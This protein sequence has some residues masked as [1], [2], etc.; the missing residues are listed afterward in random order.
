MSESKTEKV[1]IVPGW[2]VACAIGVYVT[3]LIS[4][5]SNLQPILKF[6]AAILP[7]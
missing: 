7:F 6:T 3:G 5:L 1:I 2:L 4:I